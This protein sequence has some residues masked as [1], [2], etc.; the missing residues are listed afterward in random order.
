MVEAAL[1]VSDGG[2]IV[3]LVDAIAGLVKGGNRGQ[4]GVADATE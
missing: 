2:G 4:V 3:E 1:E